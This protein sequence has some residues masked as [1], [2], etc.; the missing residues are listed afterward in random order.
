L[1]NEK[2]E[3][4]EVNSTAWGGGIVIPASVPPGAKPPPIP[5]SVTA[6]GFDDPLVVVGREP[7]VPPGLPPDVHATRH[8]E[9]PQ[10]RT[11]GVG[12]PQLTTHGVGPLQLA[13]QGRQLRTHGVGPP[14]FITQGVGPPQFKTHGVGPPQF[15]THGVGPPQFRT[16]GTGG[17]VMQTGGHTGRDVDTGEA[18]GLTGGCGVAGRLIAGSVMTAV[19]VGGGHGRSPQGLWAAEGSDGTVEDAVLAEAIRPIPMLDAP[20]TTAAASPPIT[21][22]GQPGLPRRLM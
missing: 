18:G 6:L 19:G 21:Q 20:K 2:P 16:H 10:V 22:R 11:H 5:N 1:P 9:P 17:A 15:K 13:M 7:V 14:Q 4:G 8:V 12:P 3:T